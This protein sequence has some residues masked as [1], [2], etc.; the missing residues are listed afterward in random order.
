MRAPP[1]I[2]ISFPPA[3]LLTP[4]HFGA[5]KQLQEFGIL[6]ERCAVAGAS[7]GALA[8][9]TSAAFDHAPLKYTP[10][11]ASVY[12][13]QQCRDRGG[14]GTLHKVKYLSLTKSGCLTMKLVVCLFFVFLELIRSTEGIVLF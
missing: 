11:Q 8:A 13:A 3:G 4:F 10:L 1:R 12:I 2:G 14:L 9:V 7:G 6:S 5:S